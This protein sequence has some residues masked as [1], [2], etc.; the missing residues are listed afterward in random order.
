MPL[1]RSRYTREARKTCRRQR[2]RAS[3][4]VNQ[5]WS[6]RTWKCDVRTRSPILLWQSFQRIEASV[7]PSRFFDRRLSSPPDFLRL[8][9]GSRLQRNTENSPAGQPGEKNE[10]QSFESSLHPP[11][12]PAD[13]WAQASKTKLISWQVNSQKERSLPSQ[14][15]A[16]ISLQ[17]AKPFKAFAQLRPL[18]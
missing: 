8:S 17:W 5:L 3:G 1:H 7:S 6:G 12:N 10:E 2:S 13:S 4:P 9:L 11:E 14:G 15:S 18:E 16:W